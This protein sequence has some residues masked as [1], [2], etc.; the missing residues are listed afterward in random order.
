MVLCAPSGRDAIIL[1]DDNT[2]RF[3]KPRFAILFCI[4][5]QVL[6]CI[7]WAETLFYWRR[8]YNC[9]HSEQLTFSGAWAE[10][11]LVPDYFLVPKYFLVLKYFL[12]P[13]YF[14]VL[15]Y[16]LVP[17]QNIHRKV[18]TLIS[19]SAAVVLG[20]LGPSPIYRQIRPHT[21]WGPA[22]WA[23]VFHIFEMDIYC[24]QLGNIY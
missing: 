3:S 5:H 23:P 1:P 12:A 19:A 15:K 21:F 16:F 2:G 10:Y 7:T 8:R 13:K 17:D 9:T 14:L 22:N 6:L 18:S 4:L 20:K 24:Q 11:F